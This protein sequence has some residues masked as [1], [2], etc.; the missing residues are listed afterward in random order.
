MIYKAEHTAYSIQLRGPYV[1]T[2]G[3]KCPRKR[4][5]LGGGRGARVEEEATT[6]SSCSLFKSEYLRMKVVIGNN[7]I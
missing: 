7:S 1:E 3:K 2:P 5:W 6:L 4:K